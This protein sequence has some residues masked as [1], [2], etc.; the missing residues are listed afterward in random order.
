L[1]T[2]VVLDEFYSTLRK[3]RGLQLLSYKDLILCNA[4]YYNMIYVLCCV[5]FIVV[6]GHQ[7]SV[8]GLY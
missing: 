2:F 5:I 7:M 3:D 8:Y 4:M 1:F 6:N